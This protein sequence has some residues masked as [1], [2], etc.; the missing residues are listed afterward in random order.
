MIGQSVVQ[1]S[2]TPKAQLGERIWQYNPETGIYGKYEYAYAPVAIAIHDLCMRTATEDGAPSAASTAATKTIIDTTKSWTVN[3]Y[4]NMLVTITDGAAPVGETRRIVSNTATVLTVSS[5][6]TGGVE[7]FSADLATSHRY[8]I[9]H[10]NYVAKT[11]G[12]AV[13]PAGVAPIAVTVL[14]YFWMQI[15]GRA[16]VNF[17]GT[18]NPSALGDVVVPSATA[19]S[20][21]GSTV[22]A[23]TALEAGLGAGVRPAHIVAVAGKALVDLDL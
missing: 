16:I 14:Y 11:S 13:F 20:A 3:A 12:V 6:R 2:D 10:P 15:K 19:G 17:I 9:H 23:Q 21:M 18:T 7:E 1:E 8:S 4:A 5:L 22:G